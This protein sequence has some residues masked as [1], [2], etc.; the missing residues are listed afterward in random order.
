[1]RAA[2]GSLLLSLAGFAGCGGS[3]LRIE[4][5]AGSARG[6][7]EV[8]IVGGDFARHGALVITFGGIPAR[9]V[10]IE[11]EQLIR[12]KV[13]PAPAPGAVDVVLGF[14]DGTTLELPA[15]FDYQA[16]QA[17]VIAAPD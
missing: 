16:T 4:P 17:V 14:A 1:M 15:G 5:A 2:I 12:A 8:R 7:E 11:S 13:P 10:V 3:A 6:G 9:A